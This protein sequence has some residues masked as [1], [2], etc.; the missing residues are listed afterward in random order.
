[1]EPFEGKE[2]IYRKESDL[3][4]NFAEQ[5]AS[6]LGKLFLID[7]GEGHDYLDP[8]TGFYLEDLSGW[9]IDISKVERLKVILAGCDSSCREVFHALFDKFF[10]DFRFAEWTLDDPGGLQ[11]SF[12]DCGYY[13]M[14][15]GNLQGIGQP[16]RRIRYSEVRRMASKQEVRLTISINGVRYPLDAI[17]DEL[18][19]KAH[20]ALTAKMFPA[21]LFRRVPVL[22]C[23]SV[24]F[25]SP[26]SVAAKPFDG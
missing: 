11:V 24:P 12:V 26:Y 10:D 3:H 6:K 21:P 16:T 19:A 5:E 9:L 8:K 22:D 23:A 14:E 15:P 7:S 20:E 1:M 13:S 17:P 18:R 4:V 25:D 2:F